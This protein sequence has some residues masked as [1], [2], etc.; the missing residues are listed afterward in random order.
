MLQALDL[1]RRYGERDAGTLAVDRISADFTERPVHVVRGRVIATAKPWR[2]VTTRALASPGIKG[3]RR[4]WPRAP[5]Q[6]P[7]KQICSSIGGS[8]A[9]ESVLRKKVA[10]AVGTGAL[11]F[12]QNVRV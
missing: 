6:P 10:D 4:G 8:I 11:H 2:A 9:A 3:Q 12:P 7:G 5:S 1:V